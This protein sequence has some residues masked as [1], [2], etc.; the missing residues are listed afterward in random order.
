MQQNSQIPAFQVSHSKP[1]WD[2][3]VIIWEAEVK[4]NSFTVV[5][6]CGGANVICGIWTE[7]VSSSLSE[8]GPPSSGSWDGS[9]RG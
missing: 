8:G 3:T 9:E 6:I 2:K 4:T 7:V 1:Q 5:A